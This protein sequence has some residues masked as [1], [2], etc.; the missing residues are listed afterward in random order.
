MVDWYHGVL[1]GNA[2]S[3]TNGI[4]A[5]A[6]SVRN[7]DHA[8]MHPNTLALRW[9]KLGNKI[10]PSTASRYKHM[11]WL[12]DADFREIRVR[13]REQEDTVELER[14][15]ASD[16]MRYLGEAGHHAT[17][18]LYYCLV[19]EKR[20]KI[21]DTFDT[22]VIAVTVSNAIHIMR[23]SDLHISKAHFQTLGQHFE[24]TFEYFKIQNF[25]ELVEEWGKKNLVGID[26]FKNS[27]NEATLNSCP[28]ESLFQK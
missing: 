24:K 2:Q 10:N 15:D 9:L 27:F 13:E 4:P 19:N 18:K 26:A 6:Q 28:Q 12:M 23:K 17:L 8:I 25:N 16:Y 1:L 14:N 20:K 11:L 22:K 7:G 5:L 3:E 21:T